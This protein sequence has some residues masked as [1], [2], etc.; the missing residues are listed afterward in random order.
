MNADDI[1]DIR[2]LIA[3]DFG[4]TYSGFAYVHKETPENVVVNTSWPGR[5]GNPKA[6]TALLYDERYKKVIKWGN[7]ALEEEPDEVDDDAEE[8][9]RPRPVELFKLHISNLQDKPWLPLQLDYKSA[10]EDYLTQMGKLI[11]KTIEKRWPSVKFPQQVEFILT[12]P[13]EWPPHTTKIMRECAY[14]AGLLTSLNS[15]QL[16]FTTEPEA[17]ALHCLSVI[18]EHNLKP[19]D[20]FLVADCGGGTVDLTS[21]KL[22]PDLKLSEITER[23]GDLCG[24]TF[25]D[26]EF[27]QWLGRKVGFQ[28]LEKLK[29]NHY[30][31]MQHLI[32]RF[33]CTR[34]KFKFNGDPTE[35]K[36]IKLN[37]QQ[38]CSDL[39]QYVTGESKEQMEKSRWILKVDFDSV[40]EMFDPVVNRIIKLIND[41]L[42]S[43]NEKCSAIFLVGGFSESPYL[44]RRVKETFKYN[45]PIIAV[46]ALPIA[47]IVRG[48]IT[49]GL[50]PGIIR[51]RTLKWTYGIRLC[52]K[53]VDRKDEINR[54]TDDGMIFYFYELAQRGINVKVDQKFQGEFLPLRRKQDTTS[55]NVY[56]T[57]RYIAEFCNEPEMKLL[58]ILRIKTNNVQL[59]INHP[60]EFSL[61]FGEMEIKATAKNKKTGKI[62]NE[63]IFDLDI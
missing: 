6:P 51:D 19:S 18:K 2:I 50:Y 43:S 12:I 32:Q 58:G 8:Q 23:V 44:F 45:V 38:Y 61:T 14:K 56:Y 57:P 17:A 3:I 22:L 54:R 15:N 62:Y 55:F 48:A 39:P 11:Q 28:A 35:Y 36:P 30:G 33:F 9:H 21:R 41:Q 5:E 7:S 10:I 29:S 27:L 60:I 24:S 34:I 13:A 1:K 4:T 59:D 40:R 16:E 52:R 37:L 31:Q 26:K 49:Y 47:A 53:W 25:I 63:T 46:P 42:N 20:S